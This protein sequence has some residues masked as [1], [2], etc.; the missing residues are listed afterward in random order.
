MIF[1]IDCIQGNAPKNPTNWVEAEW[2][3]L[4]I[5]DEIG[6]KRNS[7]RYEKPLSRNLNLIKTSQYNLYPGKMAFC[8]FYK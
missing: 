8:H 4:A 5:K 3:E 6:K 7:R 1:Y 2:C